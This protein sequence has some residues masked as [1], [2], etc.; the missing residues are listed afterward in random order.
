M[1]ESSL[2]NYQVAKIGKRGIAFFIDSFVIVLL[3]MTIYSHQLKYVVNEESL[4]I[5]FS[6]KFL[7]FSLLSFIYQTLFV[8]KY[9]VTLGKLTV[10]IRVVE[11]DTN[12]NPSF[13]S[14]LLRSGFR[15]ISDNSMMLGYIVAFFSPLVQTFHDKIS[16]TVVVDA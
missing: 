14:A 13:R 10:R 9:G 3:L 4:A 8:W 2:E 11:I 15:V 6:D 5:F 7:P 1:Q 12:A 16:K